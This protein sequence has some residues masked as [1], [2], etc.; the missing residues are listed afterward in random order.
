MAVF[1]FPAAL[2]NRLHWDSSFLAN[3]AFAAAS[4]HKPCTDYYYLLKAEGFRFLS[5]I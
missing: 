2:P 1:D 3:I 5:P 4:F